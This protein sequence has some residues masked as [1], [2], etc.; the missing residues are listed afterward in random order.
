[1][2]FGPSA[3]AL[4]YLHLGSKEYVLMMRLHGRVK[5]DDFDELVKQFTGDIFQMPPVRAAVKRQRRVRTIH[6]LEILEWDPPYVLMKAEVQSGTYIRTLCHDMGEVLGVGGHMVELR[7]TR[8]AHI[9]ESQVHTLQEF[10]DFLHFEKEG[11]VKNEDMILPMEVLLTH[12]PRIII[13]ETAVDALCHG[14]PLHVP[15]ILKIEA[16]FRKG[17][18]VLISAEDGR[19]VGVGTTLHDSEHTDNIGKGEAVKMDSV[20]MEPGTFKKCWRTS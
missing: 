17:A 16:P 2:A 9:T 1:M 8:T 4:M 5:R 12:M 20:F 19:A 6:R 10:S 3:R 11:K 13:K 7:R 18:Q 14:S 15:G